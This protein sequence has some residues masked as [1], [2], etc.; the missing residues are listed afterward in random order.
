MYL[1]RWYVMCITIVY[2]YKLCSHIKTLCSQVWICIEQQTRF[3]PWAAFSQFFSIKT[4]CTQVWICIEQQST[5]YWPHHCSSS[6]IPIF[7]C[8][9]CYNIVGMCHHYLC[10]KFQTCKVNEV[11]YLMKEAFKS[12]RLCDADWFSWILV[13]LRP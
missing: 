9:M 1:E 4:W 2:Y 7:L 10:S 12:D 8:T 11:E 3:W 13:L 6:V 5:I